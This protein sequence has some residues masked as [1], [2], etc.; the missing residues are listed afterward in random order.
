MKQLYKLYY[1]N[2]YSLLSLYPASIGLMLIGNFRTS[3]IPALHLF[4]NALILGIVFS[5][6]FQICICR[7]LWSGF[8]IESEPTSMTVTLAFGLLFTLLT[9]IFTYTSFFTAGLDNAFNFNFGLHW[10]RDK[11]G[12]VWHVLATTTEYLAVV[13]AIP[14]Y[15]VC[16]FRRMKHFHQWEAVWK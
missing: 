8:G 12:F 11:P 3:E 10:T 5:V 2:L 4:G 16:L 7:Q 14:F 9:F 15:F 1:I 6:L 13:V